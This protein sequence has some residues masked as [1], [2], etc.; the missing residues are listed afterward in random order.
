MK[1]TT[2]VIAVGWMV[3]A[4]II[5]GSA[6]LGYAFAEETMAQLC[7]SLSCG[8][9]GFLGAIMVIGRRAY[10]WWVLTVLTGI[11][12]AYMTRGLVREFA[13]CS[14]LGG[15]TDGGLLLTALVFALI[16]WL[17]LVGLLMD[18]PSK[19]HAPALKAE[20]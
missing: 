17:A 3:V 13:L 1:T 14:K 20:S 4:V 10:G 7:W 16:F 18:R 19:W 6:V 8:A 12:G 11:V 5:V 2:M 9:A 15:G